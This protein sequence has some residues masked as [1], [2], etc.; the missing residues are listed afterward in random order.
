MICHLLQNSVIVSDSN[1]LLKFSGN[2][3]PNNLAEPNAISIVPLKLLY[4]C[5]V[6][7]NIA[8]NTIQIYLI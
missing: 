3:I 4:N 8:I 6:Y 2:S 5:K 7:P 1:G